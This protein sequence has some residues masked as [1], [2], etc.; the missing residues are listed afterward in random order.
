VDKEA[1]LDQAFANLLTEQRKRAC[2][3]ISGVAAESRPTS[4][5]VPHKFRKTCIPLFSI[6]TVLMPALCSSARAFRPA[7]VV[8]L[9]FETYALGHS[10]AID[11]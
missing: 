2:F 8:R 6:A 7:D 4:D 5:R 3:Y 1:A 10:L 9:V 11:R